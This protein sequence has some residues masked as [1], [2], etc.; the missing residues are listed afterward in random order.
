MKKQVVV[1]HGGDTFDTYKEYLKFLKEWEIDFEDYRNGKSDWKKGLAEE[2]GSGFEVIVPN[3]P[4]KI[5]AKYLEWKIWFEKFVSHLNSEVILV[6]H[7]LGGTFLAKYLSENK[8]PKKILATFLVAPAYDDENAD[9][10]MADFQIPKS[11]DG[12]VEQGGK[13]FI[14]GSGDDPVVPAEDFEKYAQSLKNAEFRK[15]SDRGHFNQEK[16]SELIEDIK[17]L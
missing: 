16:L 5:N 9:Y 3:M 8:F 1:I 10:S 12:L 11:L 4:N 6:G 17:S 2:L 13:I 15:F 7:S 14:Y